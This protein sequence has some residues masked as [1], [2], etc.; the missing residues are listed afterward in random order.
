MKPAS[1]GSVRIGSS[2]P[3][4]LPIVDH[5]FLTDE[6]GR[7]AATL[8]DG[9]RLAR[10]LAR[11]D[12]M[13]GLLDGEL[14][15]GQTA[16]DDEIAEYMRRSIGGYW[17]PVGT[18][19]MGLGERRRCRRGRDRTTA[20]IRQRLRR[21][22]LDHAHDPSGQ[23]PSARARHRRADRGD[24]S[25]STEHPG[26][27]VKAWGLALSRLTSPPAVRR[28]EHEPRRRAPR[29]CSRVRRD[30]TRRRAP[31]SGGP[32]SGRRATDHRPPQRRER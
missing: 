7:D 5:G 21:R 31:R 25:A 17:H 13:R 16:G 4:V 10:R 14:A 23:Y 8:L 9:I 29:S 6:A 22:R 27:P 30:P 3:A 32:R 24:R 2:D 20:R 15:P 11:A 18:C 1:R 12:A 28:S 19:K 26:S